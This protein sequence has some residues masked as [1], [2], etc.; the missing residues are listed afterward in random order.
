MNSHNSADED[1]VDEFLYGPS[2]GETEKKTNTSNYNAPLIV[3]QDD[4]KGEAESEE[5]EDLYELYKGSTANE[6]Q[7]IS[8]QEKEEDV[9]ETDTKEVKEEQ[10]ENEEDY[11]DDDLEIMLENDESENVG[12][13][14]EA[15]GQDGAPAAATNG[16]PEP[17]TTKG[18]SNPLVTIKPGQQGKSSNTPQANSQSNPSA[19]SGKTS[20]GGINLEA[21]GELNGQPI[22]D[23]DLDTVED[24]PWR[25]P[26]ADITDF[27]NYG[28]NEVT[29]RAYCLKQKM[30]RENKKMMGDIDMSDFMSMGMM[31]PTSMM[32]GSM[33]MSIG[34]MT[35]S[36][37]GMPMGM[38]TTVG[39]G[40]TSSSS[41]QG[42]RSGRNTNFPIRSTGRTGMSMGGRPKSS[43]GGNDRDGDSM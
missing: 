14:T 1:D 33:P 6:A 34:S 27:F 5:D 32:D 37:M 16:S 3:Q 17:A 29:W 30:L 24:K 39:M 43:E 19:S 31:M 20:T 41:G 18:G 35:N 13:N 12:D 9:M 25:K 42:I 23:V 10:G 28:F 38:G 15:S 36:M 4:V 8:R 7:D 40:T 21:V 22:T 11:S 2:S 26:G